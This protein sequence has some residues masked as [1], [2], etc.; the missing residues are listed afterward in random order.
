GVF[1]EPWMC[2]CVPV[3]YDYAV[4]GYVCIFVPQSKIDKDAVIY[5][6]VINTGL[7]IIAGVLFLSFVGIYFLAV[8]P[9]R[10]I[11]N[12]AI[13]YAKGNYDYPMNVKSH[14]EIRSL[15]DSISYMVG[16]VR[17]VDDYQKKFIANI[18][19]DFRSPLTSIKGYA[20]AMK[21]GTIPYELQGKYLGIILFEADRL[22]KLTSNLL[23]LN[24]MDNKGVMLDITSFDINKVIRNVAAAFE[25]ICRSRKI[26][27]ELEFA[28]METFVD[29]D[30]SR[31]Q[32][33]LYN[34]TDNAIKFSN[35]DSRI[36]IETEEKGNKVLVRVRDHGIGI[37][38][39]SVK[40]IW[41]RFYKADSS[42]GKDKKGTGLGLSIVKEVISAHDENISVISTEGVGTEFTF[43]LTLS[44][45]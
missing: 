9:T 13:E 18:S 39:D 30:M 32:Q 17:N 44:E 35:S 41:E 16:E 10:K 45:T 22:T 28:A 15:A 37:P 24:R 26:V 20:E 19:H 6:D 2:V 27:I 7:L 5:M 36:E 11:R 23:D 31:I 34:L 38:K 21:D 43:S 29:A 1:A 42:R 33:V 4:K 40:R 25:G 12:A 3:I 14:D 8:Y